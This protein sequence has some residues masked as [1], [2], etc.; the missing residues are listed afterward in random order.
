MVPLEDGNTGIEDDASGA[1]VLSG[2]LQIIPTDASGN[3]VDVIYDS[4]SGGYMLRMAGQ[5]VVSPSPIPAGGTPIT[6]A[7]DNPLEITG[8]TS[9]HDTAY[10]ITNGKTFYLQQFVAGC[11]GDPTASGSVIELYFDDGTEH[12]VDRIY[13]DG[14][15]NYVSY[16]DVYKTR[17]GTTMVGNGSNQV[18]VRRRRL[19]NSGQEVDGVVRGY[20][21]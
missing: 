18:I 16:A 20:E 15:T 10:T 6:V 4:T 9:P 19:S 11:Q 17:D 5:V 21:A 12:L 13:I 1:R 8:G 7:A 3:P 14:F 2:R